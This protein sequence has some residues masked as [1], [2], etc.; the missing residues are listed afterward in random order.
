MDQARLNHGPI[1]L[2]CAGASRRAYAGLRLIHI[3]HGPGG[4]RHSQASP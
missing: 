3:K 2:A 1:A 4:A